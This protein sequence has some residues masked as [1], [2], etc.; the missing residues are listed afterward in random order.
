VSAAFSSSR[1]PS[2]GILELLVEEMAGDVADFHRLWLAAGQP[3]E[4]KRET[5]VRLAGR[6]EELTAVRRHLESG[7]GLLLV[8]GEAGIGKTALVS[9]AAAGTE[10]F[11]ATAGCR[12]LSTEVPLLPVA[13][14]LRGIRREQSDWFDDALAACPAYVDGVLGQLLPELAGADLPPVS[15]EWARQRLF[16]AVD[17]LLSAL[18]EQRPLALL[19]EDAH[20]SDSTTLDL[21][22]LLATHACPLVLTVRTEDPDVG[23]AFSDWLARVGRLTGS[24]K[25][26]LA[27]LSVVET[28]EQLAIL[29]GRD[30]HPDQVAQVYARSLG[31]PLFTEQLELHPD[32]QPLP[33]LLADLLRR[34]LRDLSDGGWAVA[35]ALGVAD[36]PLRTG[37]LEQITGLD[38]VPYLRELDQHRLLASADGLEVRLRHPLVADAVRVHLVAGEAT[39]VHRRVALLLAEASDPPAAEI[40][41]HWAD[42]GDPEQELHWRIVAARAASAGF[43][44]KAAADQWRRVLALWPDRLHEAGEPTL[45]RA[46]MY[47]AVLDAVERVDFPGLIPIMAEAVQ[48]AEEASPEHRAAILLRAGHLQGWLGDPDVA[49]EVTSRAVALYEELPPS[50][51]RILAFHSLRAALE[52]LGRY[53][54]SAEAGLRVVEEARRLGIPAEIKEALAQR[55]WAQSVAGDTSG[56]R[57]TLKELMAIEL[58]PPDPFCEIDVAVNITDILLMGGAPADELLAVSQPALDAADTWGLHQW[59]DAIL[60]FNVAEALIAQG[61]VQQAWELVA[62]LTEGD[63]V[64]ERWPLLEQRAVLELMRGRPEEARRHIEVLET[65]QLPRG[66]LP[67]RLV[68]AATAATIDLWTGDPTT[69]LDRAL[70]VLES[71]LDTE[72]P[73]TLAL[74]LVL[75]ARAAADIGSPDA[76]DRLLDLR[77]RV[78]RDPF[79]PHPLFAGAPAYGATWSAEVA[80]LERRE[81]VDVWAAAARVW[82]HLSRPYDAAYCRWRGAQVA[83]ATQE[84]TTARRLLRRAATDARGHVPLA[85]AIRLLESVGTDK[86]ATGR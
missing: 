28:A 27:P 4:P 9:A 64:D 76:A 44:V 12:P 74:V 19:V 59:A 29:R 54:E 47:I 31:Q 70:T 71:G 69:A 81:R 57:A 35:R 72:E 49:L 10:T 67:F 77:R 79:A 39:E 46:A 36:R 33:E 52:S 86:Q 58:D 38:P 24:T 37:Q 5:P 17:A 73:A 21:L 3:S 75:A 16:N 53:S 23:D 41:R 61:R 51:D 22:E 43:A 56:S 26:A 83:L 34:R 78:P 82:D 13:A 32:D 55:A 45:S 11:V 66:G 48:V 63:P 40:A 30:P 50:R 65:G 1:L 2:W 18:R 84:G 14:L 8:T 62:P 7:H 15:D 6:R 68:F 60:R 20:W 42:A 80:R 25:L 85:E